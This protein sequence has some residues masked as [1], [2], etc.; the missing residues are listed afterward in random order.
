MIIVG[1][2][3]STENL[4]KSYLTQDYSVGVTSMLVRNNDRFSED[5]RILIG[6][7]GS[8]HAEVVTVSSVNAD[9]VTIGVGATKF[10]HSASD[11]VYVLRYDQIKF[12]RST[13]TIDGSYTVVSTVDLDV[14][15]ANLKTLY[16]DATG[17]S[18]YFYKISYYHSVATVESSLSDAIPGEGY[19]RKQLGTVIGDFLTEV[20]DT[21]QKYITVP[22]CIS[23][24]NECNEDI[25]GQ[26]RKPYRFL[27]TSSLASLAAGDDRVELPT[28]MVKLDRVKYTRDD[29]VVTE[30]KGNIPIISIEEMEYYQ[31]D[32]NAVPLSPVGT[33]I[34]FAA[35]DDSTNELVV[36]P[37]PTTAQSNALK[38]YYWSEFAVFT[39]L[40]GTV[41]TPV[42]RIY[43]LFLLGRYYRMR[44]KKEDSFLSLSD[45]YLNDYTTEIVKL[46][47]AQ[48]VDVGSPMSFLPDPRTTRGGLRRRV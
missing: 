34:W 43:K 7:M 16:D 8:E 22:Q 46:Q 20:G 2:N 33:G 14:D 29:G 10:P 23:L 37:K 40:A 3:P 44:A 42:A 35:I 12:Y 41:Q 15:N 13:T 25:I 11:P 4:E 28:D 31:Y 27:S 6:E 47:R 30:T 39:S 1:Y 5:D 45:R 19:S 24:L 9:K 26:S 38:I 32:E 48:K 17:L 36:Y 21:E 18:S